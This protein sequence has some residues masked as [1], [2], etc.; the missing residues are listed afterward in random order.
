MLLSLDELPPRVRE[1]MV[2]KQNTNP[3]ICEPWLRAFE[4]HL[5]SSTERASYLL[6][7]AAEEGTLVLALLEQRARIGWP[8]RLRALGNF[9]TGYF[10]SLLISEQSSKNTQTDTLE[11]YL[12]DALLVL[13][14]KF[15]IIELSPLRGEQAL[16]VAVAQRLA[17]AG[18]FVRRFQAH[19]NWHEDVSGLDYASYLKHRPGRLRSTIKRKTRVFEQD[20]QHR[21][22][23]AVKP[24]EIAAAMPHYEQVYIR[25]W[26]AVE[27]SPAFIREICQR[28]AEQEMVRIGLLSVPEH[29]VI[30]AQIWFY[31]EQDWC[32]FKVATDLEHKQYSPGTVLMAAMIKEFFASS[33]VRGIDFLSGDDNYKR[34]WAV[35]RREHWGLEIISK[36][37]ALGCLAFAKRRF[38]DGVKSDY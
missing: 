23:I 16:L 5:L 37:N 10:S 34:D 33:V 15:G 24:D 3:F 32:L 13:A 27:A 14:K 6:V 38:I 8:C 20:P 29:G 21:I 2:L 18:C 19:A 30:A 12:A 25:R 9:Y 36:Q 7:D 35:S 28:F 17:Q 22:T 1:A 11:R 4:Q 31:L 26:G